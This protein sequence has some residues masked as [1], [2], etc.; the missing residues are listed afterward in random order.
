MSPPRAPGY[1]EGI[2]PYVPG[3][4][5]EEVERELGLRDT[6]KLASNENPLGPSPRAVEAV[7]RTA[8]KLNRYPDGGGFYL[9]ERLA[10]EHGVHRDQIALGNGSTEIVELLARTFL[11]PDGWAVIS[12]QA[13]IM[14]RI[15]VMAVNGRARMV[16]LRAMKHDLP[17]MAE[18]ATPDV[19]LIYIANPNNPTG[20]C[21]RGEELEA[22]MRAV[23]DDI[24][25]VLDEAYADYVDGPDHPAG[26]RYVM[27]GRHVAVLRTFSKIHGLAGLR[28]GYAVTSAEIA[29]SLEKVRSPFNTSALA[30]AAA[31]AALDDLEHVRLS[32]Q[33]NRTE[34]DF[35]QQ[36]MRRRGWAFTP[37][38]AN[39]FLLDLQ[40]KAL[41]VY[42][43]LLG[44]GVIVRPMEAYNF[45]TCLRVT[46]GTRGENLRF[47]E[48][49]DQVLKRRGGD[50]TGAR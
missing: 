20:T 8:E 2:V 31:T 7:R 11:G 21:V 16:P 32:T 30:Q 5:M 3:K 29:G 23:R 39:F 27:A 44:L 43:D 42:E 38:A 9:R 40:R 24:I 15:A 50:A 22:L 17:A 36:E 14:Y 46:I 48:A 19:R 37:T 4:P 34:R 1:I 49:L 28:I 10:A 25:V 33:T 45:P 47:L 12:D 26:L 13:F 35:V 41:P 18:A 6:I